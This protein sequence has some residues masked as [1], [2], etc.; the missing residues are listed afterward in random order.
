M[1]M[2]IGGGRFWDGGT[3][4]P[5]LGMAQSGSGQGGN[6]SVPKKEREIRVVDFRVVKVLFQR[7]L[8]RNPVNDHVDTEAMRQASLAG[9]QLGDP[10]LR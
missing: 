7:L 2:S 10:E 3:V 4:T 9:Q 8:F 1:T 5:L 6:C